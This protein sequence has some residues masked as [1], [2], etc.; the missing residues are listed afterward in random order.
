VAVEYFSFTTILAISI[1][2]TY[3]VKLFILQYVAALQVNT[4]YHCLAATAQP[5]A[6]LSDL[7][8]RISAND[9]IANSSSGEVLV[10][11]CI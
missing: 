2:P 4:A 7:S 1:K 11:G 5:A 6:Y 3:S 8:T 10:R 9:R